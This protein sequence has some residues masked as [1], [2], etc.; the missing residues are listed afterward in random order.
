MAIGIVD[1]PINNGDFPISYISLPEGHGGFKLINQRYSGAATKKDRPSCRAKFEHPPPR[2]DLLLEDF[3][4]RILF[5]CCYIYIWWQHGSHPY[6]FSIY[7][8]PMLAY[9]YIYQHQPD[10]SWVWGVAIPTK[11]TESDLIP[12]PKQTLEVRET[13][14]LAAE[15]KGTERRRSRR[16]G[17]QTLG[18]IG[19]KV[20]VALW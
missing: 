9:I 6:T 15:P 7:P 4:W 11:M 18:M 8:L 10:P 5:R 13:F 16:T 1:L 19:I 17:P 12:L 14:F 20:I 3:P 2:S